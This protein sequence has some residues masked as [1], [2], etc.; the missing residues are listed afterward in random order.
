MMN[1]QLD[2][3]FSENYNQRYYQLLWSQFFL[4][5]I[6]IVFTLIST[7]KN[8]T[9]LPFFTPNQILV[10]F[11]LSELVISILFIVKVPKNVP[12]QNL[13]LVLLVINIFFLIL[14]FEQFILPN[15][16][17]Q[18]YPD[19]L[20]F[21]S[22]QFFTILLLIAVY[23]KNFNVHQV[24]S[25]LALLLL[26]SF[27]FLFLKKAILSSFSLGIYGLIVANVVFWVF[28][29]VIIVKYQWH[30]FGNYRW[31][32]L[33]PIIV[34]IILAIGMYMGMMKQLGTDL[35]KTVFNTINYQA[36]SLQSTTVQILG[37]NPETLM[38]VINLI[39]GYCFLFVLFTTLAF[40]KELRKESILLI[41]IGL[42]GIATLPYLGLVRFFALFKFISIDKNKNL[43]KAD[44]DD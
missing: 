37:F 39:T 43:A 29:W 35:G 19:D 3:F 23:Y 4:L 15:N 26:V 40:S 25:V 9:G 31:K 32:S 22:L 36:F 11:S 8:L 41:T 20:L 17:L 27:F 13:F 12:K 30:L 34:S 14:Y 7:T 6:Y 1:A 2:T 24:G 28:L 5:L 33:I 44:F 18:Y 42:T 10:A 38:I 21:V 16:P